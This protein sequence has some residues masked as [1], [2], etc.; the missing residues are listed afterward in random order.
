MTEKFRSDGSRLDESS[1]G[2]SSICCKAMISLHGSRSFTPLTEVGLLP[3][4]SRPAKRGLGASLWTVYV[5]FQ[6]LLL[7]SGSQ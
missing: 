7:V 3:I 2:A 6:G 5:R 1:F 4:G